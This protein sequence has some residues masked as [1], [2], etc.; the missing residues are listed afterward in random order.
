MNC[1][2][3]KKKT[4]TWLLLSPHCYVIYSC[5]NLD[6]EGVKQTNCTIVFHLSKGEIR[7]RRIRNKQTGW[8]GAVLGE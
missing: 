4:R 8:N 3:Q 2:I 7:E 5:S 6:K 1:L